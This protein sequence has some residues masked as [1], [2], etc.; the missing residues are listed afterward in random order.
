MYCTYIYVCLCICTNIYNTHTHTHAAPSHSLT[1]RLLL[2][3][4]FRTVAPENIIRCTTHNFYTHISLYV[5]ALCTVHV[6]RTYIHMCKQSMMKWSP[7]YG[8]YVHVTYVCIGISA[9]LYIQYFAK[10]ID[11]F[12]L[13]A[14]YITQTHTV[15]IPYARLE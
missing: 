4:T 15:C 8:L 2:C 10:Y 9:I 1:L 5:C 12:V 11:A 13:T 14:A 7:D 3:T 6:L